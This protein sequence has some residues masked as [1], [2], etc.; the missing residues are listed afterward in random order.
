MEKEKTEKKMTAKAEQTREIK[1]RRAFFKD[2]A[3]T[4]FSHFAE[5]GLLLRGTF[6]SPASNNFAMYFTDLQFTGLHDKNGKKIYEG[7]ILRDPANDE[8]SKINYS[9]FEVF[10]HDGDANPDYNIGYSMNR[11]HNHG[12]IGGGHIPS[13]KPKT[14]AKMEIIGNVFENK[15]LLTK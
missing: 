1:F 9:C 8:W 5:W 11:M 15:N 4:I 13:F 10:F 3:K 2:E 7:D 14:T 12:S 6:T